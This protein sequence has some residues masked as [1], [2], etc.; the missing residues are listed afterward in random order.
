MVGRHPRKTPMSKKAAEH[1]KKAS[2]HSGEA[3]KHHDQAAQHH[4]AGQHEKAAHHAHTATGH[5]RH[6]RCMPM[7]PRRLMPTSTAKKRRIKRG[8]VSRRP[9]HAVFN[10]AL[11]S[12]HPSGQRSLCP[13]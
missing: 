11:S 4:E 7:K 2:M 10:L 6:S 3:A 1:H 9:H 12:F 8:S 5:E 13:I